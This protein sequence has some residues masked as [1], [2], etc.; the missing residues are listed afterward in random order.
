MLIRRLCTL[1]IT[2]TSVAGLVACGGAADKKDA[3]KVEAKAED[4]KA[5]VKDDAKKAPRARARAAEELRMPAPKGRVVAIGGLG[6]DLAATNAA[7]KAAGAL[8]DAGNWAGG[9]LVVVQ[10]GNALG[11]GKDEKAVLALLDR[12]AD[13]ASKAGGAV[14]RLTGANEILN[15]ALNFD[16]VSAK[17]FKDYAGEKPAGEDPR[18]D[19]LPK[20]RRGRAAAFASGGPVAKKL[21]EQKLVLIVGDT[22]FAHGG[23]LEEHVKEGLDTINNLGKKWMLGEEALMPNPL[24]E[25]GPARSAKLRGGEP[26]CGGVEQVLSDL[27]VKRMVI[28]RGP[29]KSEAS[30][31]DGKLLRIGPAAGDASGGPEVLEISGDATKVIAVAKE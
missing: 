6:G 26:Y 31:C 14:Y 7:L 30:M 19:G 1:V 5:E 13:E 24:A 15:V 28:Q 29:E 17:G 25:M 23:V 3:K 21:A 10:I 22:V 9:D 4:T 11:G 20:D 12:L 16:G 8:D 27:A 2:L 18:I